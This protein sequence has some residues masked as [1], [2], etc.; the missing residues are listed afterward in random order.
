M[1]IAA[2][3]SRCLEVAVKE[4]RS[5]RAANRRGSCHQFYGNG[6]MERQEFK[7]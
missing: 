4:T 3:A 1:P 6:R 5:S 2:F 7:L